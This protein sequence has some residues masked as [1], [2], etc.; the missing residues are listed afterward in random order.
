[1]SRARRCTI[2]RTPALRYG[3]GR[4]SLEKP[5]R[6]LFV[7]FGDRSSPHGVDLPLHGGDLF[8]H[9]L[10]SSVP[11][12]GFL[13]RGLRPGPVVAWWLTGGN[14]VNIRIAFWNISM[15]RRA[16]SSIAFIGAAIFI[17]SIGGSPM[18]PSTARETFPAPWQTRSSTVRGSLARP[19]ASG[20]HR[21]R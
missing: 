5:N 18:S 13:A 2:E 8:L 10:R 17:M 3:S 16:C 6:W 7:A 12:P 20:R 19:S 1:M 14:G 4:S 21:R 11:C 9:F 15:L